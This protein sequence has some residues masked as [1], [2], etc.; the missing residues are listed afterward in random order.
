[1]HDRKLHS[2]DA[3][4]QRPWAD[5]AHI[6]R[7]AAVQRA[8]PAA[9]TGAVR[10]V[11]LFK[12]TNSAS[13][14][15]PSHWP[16]DITKWLPSDQRLSWQILKE[17]SIRAARWL[18]VIFVGWLAV[19]TVVIAAYAFINPPMSSLMV[20]RSISGM[21]IKQRWVDLKDISPNLVT[22]VI[23]SED[24]RFCR[25]WGIDLREIQMAIRRSRNGIPR[26]ASTLTMQLAK[27]LFLWPSKSYFR[28]ALEV[29]LTA[30][31][32]LFWSK[33]RIME[34]YL[35]VVEWGPGVFGADQAARYHFRRSAR[36]LGP[37]AASLLAVSLPNP[38]RRRAGKPGRLT[39]KL[40]RVI[41]ARARSNKSV[42]ACVLN[43]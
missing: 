29:P 34:V 33:R 2:D 36:R 13:G 4:G 3:A 27:N 9:D 17:Y 12:D 10:L 35:N 19:M 14:R 43:P 23:V 28:K 7:P 24:A 8:K 41:R 1:M 25:H 5:A 39:R 26:G 42:A 38:I 21:K 16:I 40:A 11:D 20:Q 6:A 31:I 22:A 18:G 30:L 37:D 32:E 15:G